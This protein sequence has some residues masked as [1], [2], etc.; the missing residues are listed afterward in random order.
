MDGACSTDE[1]MMNVYSILAGKHE[2]NKVFERF[3]RIYDN[4][5]KMNLDDDDVDGV[6]LGL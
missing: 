2:K 1:G 3:R 5:I 4:N 6:K